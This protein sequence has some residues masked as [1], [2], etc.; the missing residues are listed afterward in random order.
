MHGYSR[1]VLGWKYAST[2]PFKPFRI[3]WSSVRDRAMVL[4]SDVQDETRRLVNDR[5]DRPS[6]SRI[7]HVTNHRVVLGPNAPS[8]DGDACRGPIHRKYRTFR[9][10]RLRPLHYVT[11]NIMLGD[12]LIPNAR[13]DLDL[14]SNA[15]LAG[16]THGEVGSGLVLEGPAVQL[17]AVALEVVP[18]LRGRLDL[19]RLQGLRVEVDGG[20][21]RQGRAGVRALVD[22]ADLGRNRDHVVIDGR[23]DRRQ[24]DVG[25]LDRH[26]DLRAVRQNERTG[27]VRLDQV[28]V[29]VEVDVEVVEEG[30]LTAA[31]RTEVVD[32][33]VQD[34]REN[35]RGEQ[36]G[37]NANDLVHVHVA[38]DLGEVPVHA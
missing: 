16:V 18:V 24:G 15:Q 34:D 35:A 37:G 12:Y 13:R 31:V 33:E 8:R 9:S 17:V 5:R 30:D 4:L 7:R 36:L 29:L 19:E 28:L 32:R 20:A 10:K 11:E 25:A 14:L 1:V 21:L 38:G 6:L 23:G 22:H 26:E 27:E 2:T 3:S